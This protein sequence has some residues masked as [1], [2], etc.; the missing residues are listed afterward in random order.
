MNFREGESVRQGQLLLQIDPRPYKAVVD[1]A[2]RHA[3]QR[4]RP[5]LK[6]TPKPRRSATRQLYQAGVVSKESAAGADLERR[7]GG[8][9]HQIR[10][11]GDRSGQGKPG[12]HQ[13]L[14]ADQRRGRPARQVDPGNIVH[15]SDSTGLIVITQIHPI[16][17]VF[18]LPEDQLPQVQKAMHGGAKLTRSKRMTRSQRSAEDRVRNAADDRQPDRH[19]HGPRRS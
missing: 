14:F 13:H 12:L 3:G 5:T 10:P 4:R 15:A 11:G 6:N 7:T 18:T 16:A 19:H 2:A 17:I 1:Q 8:G 9:L